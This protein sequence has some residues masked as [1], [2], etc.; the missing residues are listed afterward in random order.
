MNAMNNM[1]IRAKI[2][3]AF[4]VVLVLVVLLGLLAVDRIGAVNDQ[5]EIVRDN[6]LP[7][8]GVNGKLLNAVNTARL[9]EARYLLS[10]FVETPA[11][12]TKLQAELEQAKA[13]VAA[14][15]S[16][17]QPMIV[18]GSLDEQLIAQFDDA[19]ATHT[20]QVDQIV[21]LVNAKNLK[22]A[23]ALANGAARTS[24]QAALKAINDDLDFNVS[25][26]KKAADLGAAVY[27]ETRLVVIVALVAAAALSVAFGWLL[28]MAVSTPIDRMTAA[29]KRLAGRDL[30][31]DIP[32]R[33]R[34]DE[35]GAMAVAVQVFKESMID[36]ERL[37]AAAREE[38]S[39]KERRAARIE[40]LNRD[41]DASARAALD[42]LASAATELQATASSMSENAEL[43]AARAYAV[44]AASE[45]ASTNV[46][47]VAAATEE[48]TASIEEI[49]RQV[50]QST[51]VAGE[52][53]TEAGQTQVA[54][55]ELSNAAQR[56]GDVVK[57]INDI[58]SQTNLLALNATIEAA[59]AGDAGKGFA[60]VASEVKSLATQT[61]RATEDIASQISAMQS[62]TDAAVSAILRI[63]AIIGRINE[64]SA[65]IAAAVEE[66]SVATQ[67][68]SRN[69]QEA[70]KG[71][72]EVSVNVGGLNQI[73]EHTGASASQVRLAAGELGRQS[74][75]LRADVGSYLAGISAA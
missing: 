62:K 68:I 21:A 27:Q 17:Y 25:E 7:S 59:R 70:A 44:A 23:V 46:A 14:Q 12:T 3:L 31:V 34:R 60:V 49:S 24:G 52:A 56:I 57:L 37:A 39:K 61:A 45:E 53:V 73:V 42:M 35:I 54:M 69:V 11:E 36:G 22:G 43:A 47:T 9:G 74:E 72:T 55:Q 28:V 33:D 13:A 66:Q 71:T 26:G 48:L 75:T 58:A 65:S 16:D 63:N 19:W 38:Q 4:G 10:A 18:R 5:A 67:E 2:P 41:F 32:G 51:T 8:T 20:Q 40:E 64:I 15:R 1:M 50:V 6:W 29:M 30:A